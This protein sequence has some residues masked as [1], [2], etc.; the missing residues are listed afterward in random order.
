MCCLIRAIQGYFVAE[1][2]RTLFLN[3]FLR[4]MRA[5]MAFWNLSSWHW[6]NQGFFS[7]GTRRNGVPAPLLKQNFGFEFWNNYFIQIT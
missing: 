3:F 2:A 4:R 6:Y 7:D 1:C 5:R